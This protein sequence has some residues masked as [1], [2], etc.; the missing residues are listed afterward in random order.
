MKKNTELKVR[1][2]AN[3]IKIMITWSIST[4]ICFAILLQFDY[5]SDGQAVGFLMMSP[6]FGMMLAAIPLCIWDSR[7]K[8]YERILRNRKEKGLH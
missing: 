2:A 8:K 3:W 6:L 5:V 4:A 7:I 1:I